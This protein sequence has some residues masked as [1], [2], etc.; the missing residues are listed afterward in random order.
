[1]L[2]H[3][4]ICTSERIHFWQA[5]ADILLCIAYIAKTGIC[6]PFQKSWQLCLHAWLHVCSLNLNK[7]NEEL[8]K[9]T[10]PLWFVPEKN[11][12]WMWFEY[13]CFLSVAGANWLAFWQSPRDNILTFGD[14]SWKAQLPALE[15]CF[16]CWGCK[17]VCRP[18]CTICSYYPNDEL[19]F[20]CLHCRKH[21][22]LSFDCG[23]SFNWLCTPPVCQDK[24]T[25]WWCNWSLWIVVLWIWS[26]NLSFKKI[27][28]CF[29]PS[30]T[31]SF[32]L[33]PPLT[34][35]YQ[36][37]TVWTPLGWHIYTKDRTE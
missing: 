35:H 11:K 5:C 28:F 13:S 24:M 36:T 32:S 22:S 1:M 31:P 25:I 14:V 21:S 19:L 8:T 15:L 20:E 2:S 16:Y 33:S 3:Y 26:S 37:N 6:H 30:H 12:L 27:G 23:H 18:A 17:L 9:Q 4:L 29:C 10:F 7:P 34:A